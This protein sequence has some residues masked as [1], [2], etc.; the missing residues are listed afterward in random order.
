MQERDAIDAALQQQRDDIA[1]AQDA[2]RALGLLDRCAVLA[3]PLL[4]DD[5]EMIK[6]IS[7]LL[8]T[9]RVLSKRLS[10]Q[11]RIALAVQMCTEA[12]RIVDGWL[13]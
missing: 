13:H 9:L 1:A 2:M 3:L 4:E 12:R 5:E 7:A 10:D 8:G 6:A 11:E